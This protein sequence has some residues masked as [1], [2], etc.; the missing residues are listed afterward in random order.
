[1][2]ILQ[3]VVD[4]LES[5]RER[6][7]LRI[8]AEGLQRLNLFDHQNEPVDVR[9]QNCVHRIVGVALADQLILQTPPEEFQDVLFDVFSRF[10]QNILQGRQAFVDQKIQAQVV[11]ARQDDVDDAKRLPPEGIGIGRAGRRHAHGKEADD[12]VHLIGDADDRAFIRARQIASGDNRQ[13]MLINGIGDFLFFPG[14]ERVFPPHDALEFGKF[15]HHERF[16][17][18]LGQKGGAVHVFL[19]CG[20][21]LGGNFDRQL[22]EAH[23]LLM[24]GSQQRVEDDFLERFY[25]VFQRD[26]FILF[27]EK[28]SVGQTGLQHTFVAPG[29][30]FQ[31]PGARVADGD[32]IGQKLSGVVHDGEILLVRDHGCGQHVLGDLQVMGVEAAANDHGIFHDKRDGFEQVF[33]IEKLSPD[34]GGRFLRFF[35]DQFFPQGGIGDHET[36]LGFGEVIFIP[37]NG[38]GLRAHKAVASRGV[39]AFNIFHLERHDLAA[40]KRQQPVDRPGKA[41]IVGG[42]AH[43]FA[44]RN[45]QKKAFEEVRQQV[46]GRLSGNRLARTQIF[47]LVGRDRFELR[48]FQSLSPGKSQRGFGR[49]AVFIKGRFFG[50]SHFFDDLVVLLRREIRN[51]QRQTSGGGQAADALKGNSLFRKRFADHFLHIHHR[52]G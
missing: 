35:E 51:V 9:G 14:Q 52:F 26:F 50:R 18:G 23:H 1:V 33:R 40:I 12:G 31:I 46:G 21:Y 45:R 15:A 44:K 10:P 42:P 47:A 16:Q 37:L 11:A 34:I 13:V 30:H 5:D 48:D 8:G 49:L 3:D 20:L 25:P 22:A 29:D 6:L 41:Q 2:E 17:I 19:D 28:R 36:L 43:G 4:P 32:E 7:E 39:A 24:G 38:K 27:K